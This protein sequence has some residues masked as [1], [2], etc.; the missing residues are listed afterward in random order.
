[1]ILNSKIL[2]KPKAREGLKNI[3]LYSTEKFGNKK[4][5]GY[6]NNLDKAFYKIAN[7]P[8]LGNDYNILRPKIRAYT[9]TSHLIF[10]KISKES[11]IIIRVLHKA[12]D[13]QKHL[14]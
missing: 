11:I 3:Y 14:S 10:Y 2:I 1:M 8:I 5:K 7:N 13:Y 9:V 6:I 4:A 12:M